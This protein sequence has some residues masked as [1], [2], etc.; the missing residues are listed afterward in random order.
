MVS[1]LDSSTPS[2]LLRNALMLY[3]ELLL[4]VGWTACAGLSQAEPLT[5]GPGAPRAHRNRRSRAGN[6]L[7]RRVRIML[8]P[9]SQQMR[10]VAWW[11][12]ERCERRET[13]RTKEKQLLHIVY[14]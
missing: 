9:T 3:D 1:A 10:S 14:T 2:L 11:H 5:A 12:S 4:F 7:T 13:P 8:A 6:G